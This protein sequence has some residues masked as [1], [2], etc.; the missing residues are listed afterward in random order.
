MFVLVLGFVFQPPTPTKHVMHAVTKKSRKRVNSKNTQGTEGVTADRRRSVDLPHRLFFTNVRYDVEE[1]ELRPF[2]ESVGQVKQ[3]KIL[4][5]SITGSSKG[6][7]F[8]SFTKPLYA[9][10]ALQTLNGLKI[11]GRELKLD[12]ATSLARRR[13]ERRAAEGFARRQARRDAAAAALAANGGV[14]PEEPATTKSTSKGNRRFVMEEDLGP[15]NGFG[16]YVDEDF[17]DFDDE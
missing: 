1:A 15:A 17:E 2:F 14:P 9:S 10:T 11:R 4:R 16:T 8:V 6:W 5:D 7:G 3:C 12:E 13:K